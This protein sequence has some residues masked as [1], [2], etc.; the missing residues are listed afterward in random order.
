MFR[1]L[2]LLGLF[3]ALAPACYAE[4]MDMVTVFSSSVGSFSKLETADAS[5]PT[6]VQGKVSFCINPDTTG[7]II[8]EG[9]SQAKYDQITLNENSRLETDATAMLYPNVNVGNTGRLEGRAIDANNFDT[10]Q[11]SHSWMRMQE[12]KKEKLT[13]KVVRVQN[14]L[15][16]DNGNIVANSFE[17][18]TGRQ[19]IWSNKYQA[20]PA[21]AADAL[22][23]DYTKQFLLKGTSPEPSVIN[24]PTDPL[25]P[26][27]F[28]PGDP[29]FVPSG[30]NIQP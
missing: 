3:G 25:K 26:E 28:N 22:H 4:S 17:R 23:G 19:L 10:S 15:N 24:D 8:L 6:E 30:N 21:Y 18:R 29:P 11:A 27:P 20:N 14:K 12:L 5:Q 13:G 7:E 2:A 16:V 9:K 1:K